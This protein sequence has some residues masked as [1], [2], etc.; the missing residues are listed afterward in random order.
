MTS[1]APLPGEMAWPRITISL[2]TISSRLG[3]VTRTLQSLLAQ[4]YPHIAVRLYLSREPFLL[5]EGVP[6]DLPGDIAALSQADPRLAVRFTPNIGPYRKILPLLSEMNGLRAL[7]ATADDDTIYPATWLSGLYRAYSRHR[8]V[9]C[10]RGHQM[11]RSGREFTGYRSWMLAGI[12]RNPDLYNLPTGKDGVLYDTSFFHP[13]VLNYLRALQIAPTADD[14]W[15]KWHYSAF[16]D[17]PT[18][19]INTDYRAQTFKDDPFG[20]SLFEVFNR[21]GGNDATIQ[22]LEDYTAMSERV[23]LAARL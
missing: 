7:V 20:K 17:V 4:D 18:Y 22:R 9:V 5:D 19:V 2:T 6:G 10:Y 23:P 21:D 11:R 16:E 3:K 15:L 1:A 8:C 14:L 13:K 12:A